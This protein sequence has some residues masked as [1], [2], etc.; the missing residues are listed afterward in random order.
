MRA[1]DGTIRLPLL[2]HARRQRVAQCVL[3]FLALAFA[4]AF[5]LLARR[6]VGAFSIP[7]PMPQLFLAA[8]VVFVWAILVREL[9]SRSPWYT[10]C[11]LIVVL[12]FALA[13]SYPGAR[14]VDWLVWPMA[15]FAV[16]SCP[17]FPRATHRPKA[18]P[19][20]KSV[21]VNSDENVDPEQILQQLTRVRFPN[22]HEAIRG[23]LLGELAPG[24]RQ[25]TVYVAFCPPFECLPRVEINVADDSDAAAKLVQVLH[26]GV[27]IEI[28]LSQPAHGAMTVAVEFF[29]TD[30]APN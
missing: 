3:L 29:A 24:E 20:S 14:I 12:L 9:S 17:P 22:G 21:E 8:V 11:A 19:N 13:C 25:T 28:R 16:V 15:M 27:Q 2:G 4:I 23:L 26:N 10:S 18:R 30:A 7:L 1:T 6:I 5:F